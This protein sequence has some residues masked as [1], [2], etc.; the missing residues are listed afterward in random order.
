MLDLGEAYNVDKVIVFWE[1]AYAASYKIE[2]SD[3][4]ANWKEI[5]ATETGR[6]K[7]ETITFPLS[8]IRY[9]RIDCIKKSGE[10]GFSIWEVSV[11]GK[12]KLVLF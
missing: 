6:G 2:I 7:V 10:W 3:D 4:K 5:Y 11:Y 1:S 9:I 12:R 8:K